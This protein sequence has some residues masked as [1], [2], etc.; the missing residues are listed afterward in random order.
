M[1]TAPRPQTEAVIRSVF[2]S[3]C[4]G[5][6]VVDEGLKDANAARA[7]QV[8]LQKQAEIPGYPDVDAY[9][10]AKAPRADRI[11]TNRPTWCPRPAD[12]GWL[13]SADNLTTWPN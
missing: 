9:L 7:R 4:E 2:R 13:P 8:A 12:F 1:P 10:K 5:L 3:R 6:P 11:R